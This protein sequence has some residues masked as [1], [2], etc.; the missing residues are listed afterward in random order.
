MVAS[1][2]GRLRERDMGDVDLI[3]RRGKSFDATRHTA[4]LTPLRYSLGDLVKGTAFASSLIDV[5]ES[6][7]ASSDFYHPPDL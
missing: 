1:S 6:Q 3:S 2:L 5:L 4:F 7:T